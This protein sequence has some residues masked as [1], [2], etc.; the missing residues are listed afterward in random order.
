MTVPDA[1]PDGRARSDVG[2]KVAADI[3]TAGGVA[4]AIEAVARDASSFATGAGYPIDGGY[5]A[6]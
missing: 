6:R 5:L 1:T 2:G 3:T 4:V